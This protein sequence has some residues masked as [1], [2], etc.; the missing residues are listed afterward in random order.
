MKDKTKDRLNFG[1]GLVAG[2]FIGYY[3]SSEEGKE[4]RKIAR[5][6]LEGISEQLGEKV[7]EQI[8]LITENV[9]SALTKGQAYVEDASGSVQKEMDEGSDSAED[10]L[11]SA[12]NSFF[13]GME[14]ARRRIESKGQQGETTSDS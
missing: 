14:K 11:S 1:L 12:R 7:Q 6:Q 5:R 8:G 4:L 3:I 10:V 13:R 9:E 2:I